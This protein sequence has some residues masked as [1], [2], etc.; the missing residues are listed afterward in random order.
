MAGTATFRP[1][2]KARVSAALRTER[3][4]TLD[5]PGVCDAPL[6]INS[7]TDPRFPQRPQVPTGFGSFERFA[8]RQ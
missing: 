2:L 1:P 6:Y 4:F 7:P 3:L 5:P 8:A